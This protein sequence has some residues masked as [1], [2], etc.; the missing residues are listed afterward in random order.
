MMIASNDFAMAYLPG[1][2]V[3]NHNEVT[4]ESKKGIP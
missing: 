1:C 4:L 2:E 3:L